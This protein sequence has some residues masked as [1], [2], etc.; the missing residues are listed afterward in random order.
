MI[1]TTPKA[2][3]LFKST[4]EGAPK[5]TA[6]AGS[7]KTL[8]KAC[9]MSGYG[10]KQPLGWEMPF[11]QGNVAVFRS[12]SPESNRHFLRVDNNATRTAL[13]Q[14]YITMSNINTGLG[15]FHYSNNYEKFGYIESSRSTNDNWWLVGH[16]HCFV[17]LVGNSSKNGT[18][19]FFFGDVP[20]LIPNDTGNTLYYS[21]SNTYDYLSGRILPYAASVS[22]SDL[23][24]PKFA[25]SWLGSEQMVS[26]LFNSL[27]AHAGS[28]AAYPDKISGG[29]MASEMFLY[30]RIN[31]E[32]CLRALLPGLL[33]CQNDLR[34]L[35]DGAVVQLDNTDDIYL[36]FCCGESSHHYLLNVSQWEA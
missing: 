34:V 27:C 36:K 30:E 25:K 23:T 4:D 10:D 28:G 18:A 7:L 16:E 3:T 13:M 32:L 20:S 12:R 22:G 19:I 17:L 15:A 5:L 2:V 33:R 8:L 31:N 29:L 14:A 24:D 6:S 1:E 9:L 11:E 21:N 35:A 26:L